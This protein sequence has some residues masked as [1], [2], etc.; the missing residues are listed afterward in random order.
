MW[1]TRHTSFVVCL[2]LGGLSSVFGTLI[3]SFLDFNLH[4][5]ANALLFFVI[6][7]LVYRLTFAKFSDDIRT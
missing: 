5:P 6:I 1:F 2:S 7:G 4:I 3:Y